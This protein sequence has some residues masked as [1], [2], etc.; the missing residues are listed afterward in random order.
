[1]ACVDYECSVESDSDFM[2]FENHIIIY[3]F[4]FESKITD[5]RLN[6]IISVSADKEL[7]VKSCM[8]SCYEPLENHIDNMMPPMQQSQPDTDSQGLI[9][10]K[11]LANPCL[12]SSDRKNLHRELMFN[13]KVYD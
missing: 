3:F 6:F 1:M 12:E 13:Q 11:K 2:K 8:N 5:K 9:V 10:P 7:I 4:P